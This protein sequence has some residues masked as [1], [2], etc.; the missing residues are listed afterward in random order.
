M[1]A[2]FFTVDVPEERFP[3]EHGGYE[4]VFPA[5]DVRVAE[6]DESV[7]A[8]EGEKGEIDDVSPVR[9]V[10]PIQDVAS[11]YEKYPVRASFRVFED[12]DD[13]VGI[14]EYAAPSFAGERFGR[15]DSF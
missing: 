15:T 4:A 7:E 12:I 5:D 10:A 9:E 1:R 13:R 6:P 14:G 11:A 2:V 8:G 3:G